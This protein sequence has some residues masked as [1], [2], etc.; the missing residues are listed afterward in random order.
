MCVDKPRPNI[1]AIEVGNDS[2]RLRSV[3]GGLATLQ[4]AVVGRS[5]SPEC[6][7]FDSAGAVAAA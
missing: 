1:C 3:K 4:A 7:E 6:S 2:A 5:A